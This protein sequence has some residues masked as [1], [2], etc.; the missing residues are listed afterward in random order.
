MDKEFLFQIIILLLVITHFV[1]TKSLSR[2]GI[3]LKEVFVA[4]VLG[5][6]FFKNIFEKMFPL[7]KVGI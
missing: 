1:S 2:N 7:Y 5:Q 6:S 3:I 4:D